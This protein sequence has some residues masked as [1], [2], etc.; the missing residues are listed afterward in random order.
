MARLFI[1]EVPRL[2]PLAILAQILFGGGGGGG[3]ASQCVG[4]HTIRIPPPLPQTPHP[5]HPI[6]CFHFSIFHLQIKN[7]SRREV[8]SS[9]FNFVNTSPPPTPHVESSLLT[10]FLSLPHIFQKT[11]FNDKKSKQKLLNDLNVSGS[12]G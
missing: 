1:E 9:N 12:F 7:N 4:K 3:V 8:T 2:R 11:S 6:H 5:H 10:S